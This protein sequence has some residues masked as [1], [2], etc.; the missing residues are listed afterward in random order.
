LEPEGKQSDV[1]KSKFKK[2]KSI[3]VSFGEIMD[4]EN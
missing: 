1:S 4:E 2:E 3:Y